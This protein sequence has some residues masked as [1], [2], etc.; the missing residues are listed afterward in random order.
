[1][2]WAR[3]MVDRSG[4]VIESESFDGSGLPGEYE[5]EAID[6]LTEE[7]IRGEYHQ[8]QSPEEIGGLWGLFFNNMTQAIGDWNTIRYENPDDALR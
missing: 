4:R 5:Q 8:L 6:I 2:G 1:M 7:R 3:E